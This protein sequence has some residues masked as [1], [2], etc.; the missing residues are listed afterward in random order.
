MFYLLIFSDLFSIARVYEDPK[1]D[2]TIE[3]FEKI[4]LKKLGAPTVLLTDNTRNYFSNKLRE[5]CISNLTKLIL[6]VL[7]TSMETIYQKELTKL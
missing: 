1:V 4:E 3:I 5:F 7:I 6:L 2:E